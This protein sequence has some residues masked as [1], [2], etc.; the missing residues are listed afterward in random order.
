MM[1]F[2]VSPTFFRTAPASFTKSGG[3]NHELIKALKCLV[4]FSSHGILPRGERGRGGGE[5]QGDLGDS[6]V[7]LR[8]YR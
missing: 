3:V 5:G 8:M 1:F 7:A 6:A 2:A 4:W